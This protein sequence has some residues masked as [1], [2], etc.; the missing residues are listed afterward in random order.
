LF[1]GTVETL[2]PDID[3]TTRTQ[4]ARIVLDNPDGS[5]SP[6]MFA[7][8]QLN[9]AHGEAVAV[10]PDDALIATGS[11]TRVIVAGD[12]GH[13]RTVAVRTGRSASGYTE[14]REGL[15][16]GEKVVTSGLSGALERLNDHTVQPA[17]ATSAP[18]PGM[19]MG[20]G[21]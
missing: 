15:T 7:T 20:D 8:V 5:L 4:R 9:P 13:F 2:L 14:I 17:P 19:P 3:P 10:V 6:G 11:Q 16:G 18:M 12:G 21:R 1:H